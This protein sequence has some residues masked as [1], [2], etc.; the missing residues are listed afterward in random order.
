LLRGAIGAVFAVGGLV[1][2]GGAFA[3]P[4][5]AGETARRPA[6]ARPVVAVMPFVNISGRPDDDWLGTGIAE[7]VIS[8]MQRSGGLS[9]VDRRAPF[10][11]AP[12]VD[13][14]DDEDRA[15][16][17]ARAVGVAWLVAGGFQR[18]GEQLRI[19]ARVIDVETGAAREIARIDGHAD[20]PFALQDRILAEVADGLVRL[21]RPETP[22]PAMRRPNA[23]GLAAAGARPN[24]GGPLAGGRF[25]S[26]S[27]VTPLGGG[28]PAGARAPG[29]RLAGR[30]PRV[31]A[32]AAG[33]GPAD[34]VPAASSALPAGDAGVL[35]GRVTVR[36]RRTL[37]PPTV[38]GLLDDAVWGNAARITE[39]VQRQP[40]DGAPATEDTDVYIAYDDTNLYLAF[41]AKYD[42]PQA[43]R[44]NRVDR[45]RA[46]FGD[47]TISVYF[48]TFLD[49]QRA[50]VFSV[51]GYGVQGDSIVS[52]RGGGGFGG[53]G[54][55][56]VPRGDR[57]WD[58]LFLSGG[59][60]V[61]DGFTAE[62]AIPFKSLRYPARPGST[63]HTWGF[64]IVRQIRD[65]DETLVWSP[66]SRD[67]AGF[68]PQMGV[69]DGMSG[70]ST[71]RNLEMQPT[72]T[73]FRYGSFDEGA[74]RVVDGEPRPEVGAN[75][76]YGLTPNLIADFTLNPDFSQIESDRPQV[77]NNQRFALFYPEMR[78]FFL[79]GAEIFRVQAPVTVVHTR[80]IV[81]PQYGAK[82]T[83]KAGKT[84]MGV[85]V[86]E[87]GPQSELLVE[88][89]RIVSRLPD[90]TSGFV[91][92][93]DQRETR[94]RLE[95]EWWPQT[96]LISWGPEVRYGRNY[97]F[98]RVLADENFRAGLTADFAKNIRYSF[99]LDQDMERYYGVDFDKR[100][101][102]MFGNVNTSRVLSIG[103]GYD[104][105]DEVYFDAVNPF[106]GRESG[107]RTFINFRP[108]SRF[109]TNVNIRTSR[110]MDPCGFF[111]AGLND[112]ERDE[113][114]EIFNV[115][116]FRALNTYQFTDRL[117]LRNITEFNTHDRTVALNVLATYR[118]NS[119]TAFY[120]GY[121]DH[122]QQHE[123][124]YDDQVNITDRGYLQTNRAVFTKIQYLFRY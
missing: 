39:F 13:A 80:T 66:V 69:L 46:G 109:S 98:S 83:G 108:T 96:W 12:A 119:G 82:L 115:N 97:S 124:F 22:A 34:A 47:D 63:P 53:G 3:Q 62:M 37:T 87:A 116:I 75:F 85:L 15:R 44:A 58:A 76:K 50:Y 18:V 17:E 89:V 60:P 86:P 25:G 55:G 40:I 11:G 33:T 77:E 100:R 24:A 93:T 20:D 43:M 57:S 65:K 42:N 8:G 90:R 61:A 118:V 29:S 122:Y 36:P 72:F 84:T 14:G 54:R 2:G 64:Q 4:A 38:D 74:G 107:F 91:R 111:M 81:D 103:G 117:A 104:W 114:G 70:L 101:Y 26:A 1:T 78:P 45:D 79:E 106:L 112:G 99:D 41:H 51:N 31:P 7:T 32:T 113:D 30:G 5:G 6:D 27:A 123:Q 71:S 23:G 94:G 110:F 9:V 49:Q 73:A 16:T 21:V 52:G 10:G 68:M 95:Y 56:G 48:D 102:R 120:V 19:V 105:G 88:L 59:Q 28:R 92:R 35:T 121:D 67:I